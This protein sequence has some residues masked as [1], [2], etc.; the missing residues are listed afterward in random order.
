M[1]LLFF[2]HNKNAP[3][4]EMG[5]QIITYYELTL[6]MDGEV[7]YFVDHIPVKLRKNQAVFMPPNSIRVRKQAT[8]NTDY[9][10]FNFLLTEE[11]A[12]AYRFPIFLDNFLGHNAELL[13]QYINFYGGT[14]IH[15][16]DKMLTHL[17]FCLLEQFKDKYFA[18][19]Y[20]DALLKIVSFMKEHR[21]EKLTLATISKATFFSPS[22]I[23]AL[24][25][26][27]MNTS[28]IH[29]LLDLRMEDAKRLLCEGILQAK[30]VADLCGF[31]DYN[32]FVRI[33]HQYVG[34]TPLQYKRQFIQSY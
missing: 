1:K 25:H 32:Y 27:E 30:E 20:S 11:E 21:T 16:E 34:M 17:L 4:Y 13:L 23:E 3:A 22:Y 14:T 12:A 33:F 28:P 8:A 5:E 29:Y 6:V 9:Y 31:S 7:N 24:F 2:R 19:Q 18:V 15:S 26:K 10:S